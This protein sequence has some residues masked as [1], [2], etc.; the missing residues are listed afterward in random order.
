MTLTVELIK[1]HTQTMQALCEI[2]NFGEELY[3][4][5]GKEFK[6]ICVKSKNKALKQASQAI[7]GASKQTITSKPAAAVKKAAAPTSRVP[8]KPGMANKKN[9][10]HIS[11]ASST[12]SNKGS[13]ASSRTN[14]STSAKG[15]KKAPDAADAQAVG[16][17]YGLDLQ[18]FTFA[19]NKKGKAGRTLGSAP[20]SR[21]IQAMPL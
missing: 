7:I 18:Q 17:K 14:S 15:G 1:V 16:A 3:D 13:A 9:A 11:I 2:E 10:S 21:G 12:M 5:F 6:A 19:G 20:G 4:T 8:A